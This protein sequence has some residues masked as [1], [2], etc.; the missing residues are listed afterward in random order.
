MDRWGLAMGPWEHAFA[1]RALPYV[2][3]G[4]ADASH[5]AAALLVKWPVL[6]AARH[7][8]EPQAGVEAGVVEAAHGRGSSVPAAVDVALL[9]WM[10]LASYLPTVRLQMGS[11]EAVHL[12]VRSKGPCVGLRVR[13]AA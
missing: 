7:P 1:C 5:S 3:C 2:H 9:A 13:C 10:A 4:A 12:S 6:V 8:R 11:V